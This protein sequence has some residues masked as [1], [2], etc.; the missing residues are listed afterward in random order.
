M[1]LQWKLKWENLFFWTNGFHFT[2]K[3][4]FSLGSTYKQDQELTEVANDL[5][6]FLDVNSNLSLALVEEWLQN[7]RS[8]LRQKYVIVPPVIQKLLKSFEDCFRSS[9]NDIMHLKVERCKPLLQDAVYLF[10][11][12]VDWFVHLCDLRISAI[13]NDKSLYLKKKFNCV[14]VQCY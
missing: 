5:S 1:S 11:K 2:R 7:R 12:Y 8:G 14:A 9:T 4:F 3:R 6:G 10:G 13:W